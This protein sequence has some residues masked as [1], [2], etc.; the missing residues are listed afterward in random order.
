[1]VIRG[2]PD[3]SLTT[4]PTENCMFRSLVCSGLTDLSVTEWKAWSQPTGRNRYLS[5]HSCSAALW[6]FHTRFGPAITLR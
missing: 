1:M 4:S 6:N 3:L 5:N 2:P